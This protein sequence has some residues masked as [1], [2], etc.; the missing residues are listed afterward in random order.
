MP[1]Q[2]YQKLKEQTLHHFHFDGDDPIAVYFSTHRI[3]T[4]TK[5]L[6]EKAQTDRPFRRIFWRVLLW[7]HRQPTVRYC[8]TRFFR[9]WYSEI[10]FDPHK[11]ARR[12]L[13]WIPEDLAH[14]MNETSFRLREV[15]ER[16][17]IYGFLHLSVQ[18]G[19]GLVRSLV[20]TIAYVLVHV[21]LVSTDQAL[22]SVRTTYHWS[23]IVEFYCGVICTLY[24]VYCL[25]LVGAGFWQHQ[26]VLWD[27]KRLLRKYRF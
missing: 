10:I 7:I 16:A 2:N 14:R 5:N 4:I 25:Y 11:A 3:L 21:S 8:E 12:H 13:D 23:R 24:G 27:V 6:L 20:E 26:K 18:L 19:S 22:T 15:S 17:M 9:L 1:S